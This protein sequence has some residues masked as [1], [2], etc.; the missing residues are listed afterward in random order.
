MRNIWIWVVIAIIVIGGGYW[1]MQRTQAPAMSD[2]GTPAAV[3]AAEDANANMPENTQM[4]TSS[5]ANAM[6]GDAA[7]TS[8]AV[9]YDGKS[10]TPSTVTIKKGG[11][12][13]WNGPS[14]MWVASGQHPEHAGY[15]ETTRAEH[16]ASGYKGPKPFDQCAKGASYSFTFDKAGTWS[17]HD[18]VN[19]S[20]FGKVIVQ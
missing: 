1:W 6:P 9:S 15:D 3:D 10:F 2:D 5:D 20:A 11:T 4:S 16:C 19:A 8:A 12:V 18:H 14:G 7:Q 13:T 17:Y